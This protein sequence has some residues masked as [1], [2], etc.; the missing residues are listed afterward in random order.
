[1]L[2]CVEDAA[3]TEKGIAYLVGSGPGDPG[4]LT[5]RAAECIRGA[6]VIIYDHLACPEVL[7]WAP[8]GCEKICVGKRAGAHTLEQ[9]EI[10]SLLVRKTAAGKKVVRLKGGDPF[11]FGRGG[12]EAEALA[13]SGLPFEV[14]PGVT[15]AVAAPAFAGIPLTHRSHAS[16]FC[17]VTGHE[18]AG[19]KP[20]RVA[21]EAL[22]ACGSTLVFLMGVGRLPAIA[23][24]L[25]RAGMDP[26][27][28]AALVRWGATPKQTTLVSTVGEIAGEAAERGVR[29]PAVLVVGSVVT[30]RERIAWFERKP[31]FGLTVLV[32]RAYDRSAELGRLFRETGAAVV[33]L[34]VLAFAP[35]QDSAGLDSAIRRIQSYD[36]IVFTSANGVSWFLE[37]VRELGGDVR[38]LA[39][40]RLA[41]IGPATARELE[42]RGFAVDA[43]PGSYVSEGLLDYFER[44][45]VAGSRILLPR[46][47]EGREVLRAGLERL[48]AVVDETPCYRTVAAKPDPSEAV[49][50][51]DSGELDVLTFTSGSAVRNTLELLSGKVKPGALERVP[52]ACIGPVTAEVARG[53]GLRVEVVAEEYTAAGLV[54]AVVAG[55][56]RPGGG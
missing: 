29:P 14:V 18:A 1:V 13:A 56:A 30:L 9:E 3:L 34:P 20:G 25:V 35:P 21:W 39:G 16:S 12:E 24:S 53:A 33:E 52:A 37:R 43:V 55:F 22:A 48:G 45:G 5:L 4:L 49:E 10:N 40:P 8:P 31:L 11:V 38:T 54:N 51:I 32:T 41:A 50:L 19:G 6:D 44:E 26:S 7:D 36:W 27:T 23:R 46:A 42:E 15:S 2:R 47:E 28:P 17:V